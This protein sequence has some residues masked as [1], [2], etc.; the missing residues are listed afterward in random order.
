[1]CLASGHNNYKLA[2]RETPDL[3]DS[4]LMCVCVCVRATVCA[5]VLYECVGV[6]RWLL[7]L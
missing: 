7:L 5:C 1:M 6:E 2:E 4:V 3:S